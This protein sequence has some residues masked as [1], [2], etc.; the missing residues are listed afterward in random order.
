MIYLATPYT[1]PNEIVQTTRYT[2]ACQ[3]QTHFMKLGKIVYSPIAA[4][5]PIA[6]LLPGWGF[7]AYLQY[8]CSI[9]SVCEELWV[10]QMKGWDRSPGV[11]LERQTAEELDIP[12]I[13]IKP[14][15]A[16]IHPNLLRV[17][18]LFENHMESP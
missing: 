15:D 14:Q 9:L 3:V 18:D 17:M 5:V 4:G 16:G 10:I 7:A 1:H 12:T 11:S 6:K 13:Y 2:A 8:D